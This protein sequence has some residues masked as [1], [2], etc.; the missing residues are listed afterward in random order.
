MR[1]RRFL[2]P[3]L[4]I[5]PLI[6]Q[7]QSSFI[8]T[9]NGPV[10]TKDIDFALP[11]EHV[12]TNF[13]GAKSV[14]VPQTYDS[15]KLKNIIEYFRE[16]NKKGVNLVFECTPAYIGR[17]VRLLQKISTASKVHIVTNTGFYAA[18]DKKYLPEFVFTEDARRIAERWEKEFDEG[19]DGTEIK[20]GFIKIGV[21]KGPLDSIETKLLVA[22]IKV[23][24]EKGLTIAV[25]T[26]DYEAAVNEYAI[27]KLEKHQPEKLL[28]VHAQNA[29]NEERKDLASKGVF[30][31]LDGVNEQ[32]YTEYA[33][34]VLFMKENDLLHMILLSHDDGWA[35]NSNGSYDSVELFANGNSVPYSTIHKNLIPLLREKGLTKDEIELVMRKNVIRC[36]ALR[37]AD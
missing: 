29:T 27:M 4:L 19:I 37:R 13:I 16:L 28:W 5:F 36:F 2:I 3:F 31:S 35:V 9:V 11:H 12:V 30:V 10:G 32:N 17:D 24:K 1:I 6:L 14:L 15:V 22:A 34:S 18:A 33:E 7:A 23:S 25:H 26:G 21:D 8:M 20:P